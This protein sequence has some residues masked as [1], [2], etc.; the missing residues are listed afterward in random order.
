[1]QK[2]ANDNAAALNQDIKTQNSERMTMMSIVTVIAF[3]LLLG[4]SY[5]II[6]EIT[7]SLQAMQQVCKDMAEGDFRHVFADAIGSRRRA[8]RDGG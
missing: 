3:V 8:G 6:H 5:I 2:I 7:Q 4:L 1:M